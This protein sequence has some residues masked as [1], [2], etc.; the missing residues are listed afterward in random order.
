MVVGGVV[1][2]GGWG[3]E[4]VVCVSVVRVWVGFGVV[5]WFLGQFFDGLWDVGEPAWCIHACSKWQTSGFPSRSGGNLQEGGK[6]RLTLGSP[7]K[8]SGYQPSQEGRGL[9]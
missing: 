5:W 4:L 6:T 1:L 7:E 9:G 2:V 8:L 3:V